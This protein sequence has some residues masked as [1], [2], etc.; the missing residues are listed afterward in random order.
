MSDHT[1][2]HLSAGIASGDWQRLSPMAILDFG[3]SLLGHLL[4]QSSALIPLAA[5]ILTKGEKALPYLITAAV[6]VM[7]LGAVIGLLAYLN[8]RF[9]IENSQ[10]MVKKGII[11]R[12][13]LVLDFDRVQAINITEPVYFRPFKLATLTLESAG[14]SGEEVKLNGVY[15]ADAVAVRQMVLA[16]QRQSPQADADTAQVQTATLDEDRVLLTRNLGKVILYGLTNNGL[17]V[18]AGL[19]GSAF[20]SQ[21]ENIGEWIPK[22][23][24]SSWDAYVQAG[25][26]NKIAGLLF[27]I[28]LTLSILL[29]LSVVAAILQF[30]GFKLVRAGERI[31][32]TSGL[33]E[34]KEVSLKT[35]K[36]QAVTHSQNIFAL[37]L[38]VRHILLRQA[39]FIQNAQQAM[40][41]NFVIISLSE[42]E[43]AQ[44]TQEMINGITP[45][46]LPTHKISKQYLLRGFFFSAILPFGVP[47]GL[48]AW[49]STT[50]EVLFGLGILPLIFLGMVLRYRRFRYGF[51]EHYGF[52]QKGLLGKS[53][54]YFPLFKVQWVKLTQNPGQRRLGL[55]DVTIALAGSRY[56]IPYMPIADAERLRD[57][58]LY[59]AETS[60]EAWI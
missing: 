21:A 20:G 32:R 47:I 2:E 50:P 6:A 28:F 60:T 4:N 29:A 12:K 40:G 37:L 51:D 15:K 45:D 30:Y 36:V 52:M 13:R 39:G 58:A 34:L 38:G 31:I 7:S 42:S 43:A 17:W 49:I 55:A 41:R 24:V 54:N 3:I 18:F 59:H 35:S 27:I 48:I 46:S 14:S 9:R 22:S 44:I 5:I 16:H 56:H 26:E 25:V 10:F 53:K 11:S 57:L 33:F 1:A 8:F 23:W 19:F